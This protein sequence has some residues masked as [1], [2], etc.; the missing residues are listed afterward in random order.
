MLCNIN[1]NE[2][3]DI[4]DSKQRCCMTEVKTRQLT[5]MDIWMAVLTASIPLNFVSNLSF[6]YARAKIANHIWAFIA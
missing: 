2:Y 3:S 6:S 4:E 5:A 1:K